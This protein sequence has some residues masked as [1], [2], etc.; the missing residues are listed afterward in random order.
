MHRVGWVLAIL[1]L[2]A[3]GA[4][5]T[6]RAFDWKDDLTLNIANWQDSP[7]Q[8]EM[9]ATSL[10]ALYQSMPPD[11]RSVRASHEEREALIMR[12]LAF[13]FRSPPAS[14]EPW[15]LRAIWHLTHGRIDS[16]RSDYDHAR[17]AGMTDSLGEPLRRVLH[18]DP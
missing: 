13:L 2:M 11:Y 5:T 1:V 15:R 6:T 9:S 4:R 3:L 14:P 10:L 7:A 12:E 8:T 16:A 17:E 18:P